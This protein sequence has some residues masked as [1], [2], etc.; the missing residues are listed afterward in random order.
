MFKQSVGRD[1]SVGI[2]TRYWLVGLGIEYRSIACWDC[3]FESLR[4]H[5]C[6]CCVCCTMR[7]KGKARTKQDRQSTEGE[8][9]KYRWGAR[10]SAPART[11]RGAHLA[12]CVMATRC[13]PRG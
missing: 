8:N 10:V 9:K 13:L 7:T 1:S 2:A 12:V 4:G 6:L 3:V 5:G 11:G